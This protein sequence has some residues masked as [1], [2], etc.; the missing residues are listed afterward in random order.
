MQSSTLHSV[1]DIQSAVCQADIQADMEGHNDYAML[2]PDDVIE[3]Q[4]CSFTAVQPKYLH[5]QLAAGK[6]PVQDRLSSLRRH[7]RSCKALT[8][9]VQQAVV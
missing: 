6:C 3:E 7:Y 9:A 2:P 8:S 4:D 5:G 1:G